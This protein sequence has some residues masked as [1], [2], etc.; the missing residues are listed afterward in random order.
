MQINRKTRDI[1]KYLGHLKPSQ[2]YYIALPVDASVL[3]RLEALGF[4][5]PLIPGQRVL[6]PVRG[7]ASRRNAEG[8]KIIHRDQPMEIAFRQVEWRWKQFCG[9]YDT[10]EMSKIVD[11][12]YKRYPR[13]NVVPYSIELEIRARA[14][15]D[16]F[17]IAGPFVKASSDSLRATNTAKMFIEQMGAFEVLDDELTPWISAPV[18]RLNWR[19]LPEGS[20][21]WKSA[22]PALEEIIER[23][24][25]GNQRVIRARIEAVGSQKPDFIAVGVGGFEGYIAFGFPANGL[26]VLESPY[27]N[28]A[29]YVLYLESWESLSQM[30][31]AQILDAKAHRARIVHT[32]NWFSELDHILADDLRAA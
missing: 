25:Q 15:G 16:V 24:P 11:V 6:P 21:P 28:N 31:K 3:A 7:A 23:L 27:V 9:R 5:I 29:T 26:C 32:R 18:R 8:F 13:T 14:N 19:L 10:E 17:V 20:N 1:N 22:K 4:S 12:P 30:T 2:Q